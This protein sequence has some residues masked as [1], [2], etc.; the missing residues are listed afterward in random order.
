MTDILYEVLRISSKDRIK[1]NR[2]KHKKLR[3]RKKK[4][5]KNSF[6]KIV[7]DEENRFCNHVVWCCVD[8][9]IQ[10]EIR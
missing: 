4:I 1:N 5:G 3:L 2:F 7:L 9:Q 10:K 6:S 8:Q